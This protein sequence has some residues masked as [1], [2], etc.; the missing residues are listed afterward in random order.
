M[1]NKIPITIR[2]NDCLKMK[3]FVFPVISVFFLAACTEGEV[4][5][6]ATSKKYDA[7]ENKICVANDTEDA[8]YFVLAEAGNGKM[9]GNLPSKSKTCTSSFSN[10]KLTVSIEKRGQEFCETQA[11]ASKVYVLTKLNTQGACVWQ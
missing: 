4:K 8:V 3:K 6:T 10:A 1:G 5:K 2:K 7:K 11:V 9:R